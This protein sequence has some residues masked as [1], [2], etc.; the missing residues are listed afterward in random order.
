MK[1]NEKKIKK[2]FD[3][4]DPVLQEVVKFLINDIAVKT[5][6]KKLENNEKKSLTF[7]KI[8]RKIKYKMRENITNLKRSLK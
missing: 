7:T 1:K 4:M 6:R 3:K 5:Q 8:C 2:V